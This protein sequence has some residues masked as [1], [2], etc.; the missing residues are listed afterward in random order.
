[1]AKA[2]LAPTKGRPPILVE[3][4]DLRI[5]EDMSGR[6]ATLDAIAQVVGVS[7]STLDRWMGDNAV[8]AAYSRG[9]AIATNE[10]ANSLYQNALSGNVIAQIFW[11]KAQANW[12]DKV[13]PEIQQTA[14]VVVYIPDNGRDSK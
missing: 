12:S 13:Q 8:R 3:D 4:K 10:V 1:M 11:L 2:A 6:G 7:P 9:R 5:I 14:Q